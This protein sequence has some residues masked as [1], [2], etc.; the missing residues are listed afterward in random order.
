MFWT[1]D[2]HEFG[3]DVTGLDWTDDFRGERGQD[4][5]SRDLNNFF[6]GG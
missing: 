4:T 3:L 6:W 1:E 2:L 5:Q